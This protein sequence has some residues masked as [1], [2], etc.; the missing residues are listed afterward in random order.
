MTVLPRVKQK[1]HLYHHQPTKR[2]VSDVAC[3]GPSFTTDNPFEESCTNW[4]FNFNLISCIF[5]NSNAVSYSVLLKRSGNG[6]HGQ[7]KQNV[8]ALPPMRMKGLDESGSPTAL[9]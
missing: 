8:A 4:R 6:E 3:C 5:L 1:Y 7:M 9:F 2:F